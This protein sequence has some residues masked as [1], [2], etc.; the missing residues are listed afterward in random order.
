MRVPNAIAVINAAHEHGVRVVPTFQLFDARQADR[1]LHAFLGSSAA[2]QRFIDQALALIVGRRADG[3][4]FDFEPLPDALA[5]KFATFLAR[6]RAAL[7][8]RVPDGTLVVALGASASGQDDR[9]ARTAGRPA[10]RDGLR[11]PDDALARRGPRRAARRALAERELRHRT[12]SSRNA[13]PGKVILG[14]AR[15][16]LRLA[17]HGPLRWRDCPARQPGGRRRVRRHL[18]APLPA[19]SAEHPALPVRYD[20]I[21]DAPYFTYHDHDT[22]TYRQVWFEDAR[23][24]SRKVDL[25]LSSGL[26]GVGLW[27][28]DDSTGVRADLGP[29]P[30]RSSARPRHRVVVRG[31]LFHV[32]GATARSWPTSRRRVQ[33]R[34]TVPEAGQLGWAVRDPQGPRRGVRP[35]ELV[36]RLAGRPDG[37]WSTS[38]C[39]AAPP[40]R[41]PGPTGL[42]LVYGAGGRHW[43]APVQLVPTTVLTSI[44]V[45]A[46]SDGVAERI[47]L[48]RQPWHSASLDTMIGIASWPW[49][50]FARS[51]S[52]SSPGSSSSSF[53]RRLSGRRQGRSVIAHAASGHWGSEEA[54]VGTTW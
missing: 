39:S 22:G 49:R 38:D 16:R 53:C 1:D 26:A 18:H 28:L 23:S 29:A 50:S 40:P 54:F 37:R 6:F 10:L 11:L 5:G 2:Q 35:R 25:A 24:L 21:A 52:R 51:S 47:S 43:A 33:N 17:G 34:G 4:N 46:R 15:L 20:P 14:H 3:A 45:G 41:R 13:P 12:L 30:R 8:Q 19:S 36:G 9:A 7:L 32:A 31:S 44:G 27:A 48:R 42:T